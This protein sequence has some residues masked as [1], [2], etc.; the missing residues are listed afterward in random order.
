MRSHSH[1]RQYRGVLSKGTISCGIESRFRQPTWDVISRSSYKGYLIGTSE[2]CELPLALCR[3]RRSTR[4]LLLSQK[5]SPLERQIP[6]N[7]YNVSSATGALAEWSVTPLLM[8]QANMQAQSPF[9]RL[10]SVRS[11]WS[12]AIRHLVVIASGIR[13]ILAHNPLIFFC[14]GSPRVRPISKKQRHCALI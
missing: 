5:D 4:A 7:S 8:S 10:R 12:T 14:S 3:P 11:T 13:N 1:Y 6:K 9:L 2:D